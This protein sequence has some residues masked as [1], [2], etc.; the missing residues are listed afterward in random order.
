MS[1]GDVKRG[2]AGFEGGEVGRDFGGRGR[3]C[4]EGALDVG[5]GDADGGVGA[6]V[7]RAQ[8]PVV[9]LLGAGEGEMEEDVLLGPPEGFGQGRDARG[10]TPW[11]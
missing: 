5:G 4:F 8:E 2:E 7:A 10:G 9:I 11:L 6:P 1:G 3:G